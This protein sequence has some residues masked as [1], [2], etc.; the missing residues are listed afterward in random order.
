VFCVAAHERPDPAVRDDGLDEARLLEVGLRV[1]GIADAF[2]KINQHFPV[3]QARSADLDGGQHLEHLLGG[4]GLKF[5]E[6]LKIT[7]VVVDRAAPVTARVISC[8]RGSQETGRGIG[9]G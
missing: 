4:P 1:V 6:F 7:A 9:L 8:R 3:H 5:E 2:K